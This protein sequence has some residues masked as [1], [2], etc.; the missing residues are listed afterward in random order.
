MYEN[1]EH[2]QYY[3]YID[4]VFGKLRTA[5]KKPAPAK[6]GAAA[7]GK[8]K[9][10]ASDGA[11][12]KK[13]PSKAPP[14]DEEDH[15]YERMPGVESTEW[16]AGN[17]LGGKS[18]VANSGY[19]FGL[20]HLINLN[21]VT[22]RRTT[23]ETYTVKDPMGTVL[24]YASTP[25]EYE[26][27]CCGYGSAFLTGTNFTVT[28]ATYQQVLSMKKV[29][30]N[31]CFLPVH[32][33]WKIK[34][35]HTAILG[36]MEDSRS[37]T[38]YHLL[39]WMPGKNLCVVRRTYFNQ[40][41]GERHYKVT[42]N[43]YPSD[44]GSIVYTKSKGIVLQFPKGFDIPGRALLLSGAIILQYQIEGERRHTIAAGRAYH[45]HAP[46]V[47]PS[48]FAWGG[49]PRGMGIAYPGVANGYPPMGG[50]YR[51][52]GGIF[53]GGGGYYGGGGW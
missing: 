53:A 41:S 31:F 14:E 26:S 44:Y 27:S 25:I 12:S 47:R 17:F 45:R 10:K 6:G 34:L 36:L 7:A 46:V 49:F 16:N 11:K 48:G 23:S 30:K 37:Y 15:V 8:K 32:S 1:I 42:P 38:N 28:T 35:T 13:P 29:E 52:G 43:M 19:F 9:P 51:G 40:M 3:F 18:Q 22:I 50:A 5:G 24:Y 39:K 21:A 33:A 2:R 20:H 4:L